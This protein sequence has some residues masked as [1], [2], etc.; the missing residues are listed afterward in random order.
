MVRQVCW[1]PSEG[2]GG[3]RGGE[4]GGEKTRESG[5]RG[6]WRE[7]ERTNRDRKEDV[8]MYIEGGR[9]I[10]KARDKGR[11]IKRARGG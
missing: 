9:G 4:R 8:Y 5:E 7:R 1:D 3:W 10:E 6:K 11:E 2:G